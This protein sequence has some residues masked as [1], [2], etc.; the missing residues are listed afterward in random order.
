M[1]LIL[2]AQSAVATGY[3]IDNCVRLNGSDEGLVRTTPSD[4]PTLNTKFTLSFWCKLSGDPNSTGGSQFFS[5]VNNGVSPYAQMLWNTSGQ[6]QCVNYIAA[7]PPPDENTKLVT[8]QYFRDPAAWYH[9]IWSF[10]STPAT[11]SASSIK[12]FINGT[13]VTDFSATT[14]PA[15]N[16]IGRLCQASVPWPIGHYGS[17]LG[18]YDGYFAEIMVVDGQ[19][20]DATDFGEFDEDS[21]TLWKPIDI[22]GITVGNQGFYLDFKDSSNL[23]NLVLGTAPDFTSTNLD[24]SNQG[25]D[26][27]TNNFCVGNSVDNYLSAATF[28][29]GNC[30]VAFPTSNM[31][32]VTG[33]FGLT[34]GLWYF[35]VEADVTTAPAHDV[36]GIAA[37]SPLDTANF[38]GEEPNQY[39]YYAYNGKWVTNNT[40]TTYGDTYTAND[41]IG[42]YMDLNANKLYFAKNGT[43]QNSG[44]GISI[45]AAASTVDGHYFP[46]FGDWA[47]GAGS[48]HKANFGGCS[49]FTVSSGNADSNGYGNFEYSPNDGGS[50]SFDGS[51][52]NFLAICTKNLGSDGG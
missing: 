51:A 18:D 1:P 49:A 33:T 12:M 11:P 25:T 21:P 36:I 24:A 19:A 40:Q 4:A 2:G 30:K 41:I 16:T 27:P 20:L 52:K 13:A 42:V 9:F 5:Y 43:I 38:L 23:G 22:S 28:S 37:S 35:E 47:T 17:S 3:S 10:D 32:Y 6:F 45:T 44:T 29:I 48:T 7:T 34:A 15:Q 14:Y 50:A 8:D 39:S 46:A 26:S 31:A